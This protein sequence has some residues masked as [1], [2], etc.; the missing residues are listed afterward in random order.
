MPGP[1]VVQMKKTPS[2]R[3]AGLDSSDHFS[4]HLAR[5][6]K[7]QDRVDQELGVDKD[8]ADEDGAGWEDPAMQPHYE[9]GRDI[10][11]ESIM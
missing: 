7:Q 1:D 3:H 2:H 5:G 8:V 4:S 10:Q 9:H 6:S 11:P